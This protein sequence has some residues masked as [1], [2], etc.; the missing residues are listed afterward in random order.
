MD[1]P[2]PARF[3]LAPGLYALAAVLMAGGLVLPLFRAVHTLSQV[4]AG[5]LAVI[6]TSAWSTRFQVTTDASLDRP[7]APFGVPII[8]TMVLL[9]TAAGFLVARRRPGAWLGQLGT[10]F[11]AGVVLTIEMFGLGQGTSEQ[12]DRVDLTTELGMW[13]LIGGT[14]VAAAAAVV[15]HRAAAPADEDWADP[16][17][18]YADTETPPSGFAV[19]GAGSGEVA[20]TVLPPDHP[21]R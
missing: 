13:L 18:A 9:V 19:P 15:A 10:V 3:F 14:L 20:I 8:V 7:G 16:S 6:T 17:V 21:A 4:R 1:T 12:F 2:Q 5:A 11:A